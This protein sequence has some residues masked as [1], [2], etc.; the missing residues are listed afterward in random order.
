MRR[1]DAWLRIT[2]SAR[3]DNGLWGVDM[4]RS[5]KPA[6]NLVILFLGA[7]LVVF[8][9]GVSLVL[10]VGEQPVPTELWAAGGAVSGALVGI[11]VPAPAQGGATNVASA[12]AGDVVQNSALDAAS[13]AAQQQP[14]AAQPAATQAL[15][16]V[17][18]VG[19][20]LP[21]TRLIARIR[22]RSP[23]AAAE[24]AANTAVRLLGAGAESAAAD[25]AKAERDLAALEAGELPDPAAIGRARDA[26]SQAE[27]RHAVHDAAATAA[28]GALQEATDRGTTSASM[29]TPKT[30]AI[31]VLGVVFFAALAV[32]IALAAGLIAPSKGFEPALQGAANTLIT[33]AA[34]AG[35][36]LVGLFAPSSAGTSAAG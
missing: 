14:E 26:L 33:L 30:N 24:E 17:E 29:S 25:V 10:A 13:R 32:G 22:N 15:G 12:V 36:A 2:L 34:A 18:Q 11:L 21:A 27:A 3:C 35:G 20:A 4:N 31:L 9:F 8:F 1:R 28:S 5:D 7:A 19:D 6:A 16:T 23:R